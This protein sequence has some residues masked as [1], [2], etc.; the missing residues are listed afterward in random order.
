MA[1]FMKKGR[2]SWHPIYSVKA[3]KRMAAK[4]SSAPLQ[5]H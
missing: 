5:K 1:Q 2:L 4:Q 3:L